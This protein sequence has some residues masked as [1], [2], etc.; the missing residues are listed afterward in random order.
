MARNLTR[1]MTNGSPTKLILKFSVPMLI[2]N[3]FQQL[4]NMVDSIVVG[5]FVGSDALAAVGSTMSILFL[6]FGLTFGLS[7]GISIVISQYFGA[8][9]YENVKKSFATA[10]YIVI[11]A[12]AIMG[13]TGFLLTRTFLELLNT[14][15]TIINESE[16]YMKIAFAGI[17]GIACYNGMAAVL[18]ALG[19][20]ITPLV[21]LIIASILNVLLDL[22]FVVVFG[23]GVA[24][25]AIATIIAQMVSA[26]GCTIYA[27]L[28]VKLL[29]MP[30]REF[31]PDPLI[32]RK[33]IRLGLPVALQNSFV[34]VSL[35]ALQSVINSF[36]AVVI[37]ATTVV[38]RIE[39]LVLQPSMSL[40][41]A[42]ASFT[43]QNIGAGQ[44]DRVKQGYRS[45]SLI[46]IIFSLIMLPIMFFGGEAIMKIFTKQEDM[47]VVRYG[48]EGIRI[49]SFFY[50]FVG[51]IF[52][53]RNFL[54]GTGDIHIP[55][56]MG[57]TEVICR[58]LF[59][60][61]MAAN[62]SIGFRGIFWATAF[63]WLVTGFLG[64]WRVATGKWKG[65]S[66]VKNSV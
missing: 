7:A 11:G 2:G 48:V 55:M 18:R 12:S 25:V 36:H 61:L 63:T 44:I 34:S 3:I 51:M 45:S 41:A 4:Y 15:D 50:F 20:S 53:T 59:A 35:M 60:R 24:G 1:D 6:I 5:K 58:V 42:T 37:A 29:R 22:L 31:K 40:G 30:L 23:M 56:I 47:E 32:F 57:I 13:V 64:I 52:I 43:G 10:T 14:P 16:I 8:K 27:L 38:N 28:R 54:S 66:V 19:D 26:A 62:A 33:C 39:Q 46:I 21:F 65:K 17:L 49:T 9:D